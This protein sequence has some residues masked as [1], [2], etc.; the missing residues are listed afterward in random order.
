MGAEGVIESALP[1]GMDGIGLAVVDLVRGHQ[2]EAEVVVVL[3]VP[4]E[5]LPAE[6]LGI[7]AAAEALGKPRLVFE[8]WL[9]SGS[10]VLGDR[11]EAGEADGPLME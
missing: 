2:T 11:G 3:I 5:E 8:G 9:F 7:L 1:G 10:G 6:L 4:G